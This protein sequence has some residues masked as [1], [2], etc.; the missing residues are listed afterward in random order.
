MIS[1]VLLILSAILIPVFLILVLW[2]LRRYA[3]KPRKQPPRWIFVAQA[4]FLGSAALDRSLQHRYDFLFWAQ[5]LMAVAAVCMAVLSYR[6]VK[7]A[8]VTQT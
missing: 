3:P 5:A 2:P 8:G 1:M 6:K 7:E 4:I